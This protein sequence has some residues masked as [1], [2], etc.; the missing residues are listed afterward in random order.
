MRRRR[1]FRQWLRHGRLSA[2]MALAESQHHTSRGQ[3]K[4][5]AGRGVRDA[6][7]TDW[8]QRT[9][10]AD[11]R[12]ASGGLQALGRRGSRAGY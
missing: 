7:Q 11:G 6:V 2:A 10:A 8:R 9:L 4:A 5:R 12:T 3:K 1:R